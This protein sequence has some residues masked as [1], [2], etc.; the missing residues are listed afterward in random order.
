VRANSDWMSAIA[1]PSDGKGYGMLLLVISLAFVFVAAAPSARWAS[2][3]TVALLATSLRLSV[4]LSNP[5]RRL[6]HA[7]DAAILVSIILA[8]GLLFGTGRAPSGGTFFLAAL[9]TAVATPTVVVGAINGL[10]E[11]L[12]VTMQTVFAALCV[13]LL[14][15]MIFSQ[16]YTGIAVVDSTALFSNGTDGAPRDHL[17]FSFVTL[18]TLGYGDLSPAE[19]FQRTVAI[20]EA[21]LGQLYL[22]AVVGLLVGNV[23]R[24]LT[25]P[26]SGR[27]QDDQQ[28]AESQN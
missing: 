16:M 13:F 19:P 11:H 24:G 10:R 20:V 27:G 25:R 17:Y 4:R 23:G 3:V 7:V 14:L 5:S 28:P 15:G 6:L 9:L 26:V 22:V 12:Q 1:R 8:A 2:L 21:V 18:T